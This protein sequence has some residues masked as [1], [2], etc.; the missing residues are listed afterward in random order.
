MNNFKTHLIIENCRPNPA[1]RLCKNRQSLTFLKNFLPPEIETQKAMQPTELGT[2]PLTGACPQV[3]GTLQP[4]RVA[5]TC[6]VMVSLS[7]Q[8][9]ADM[10]V[11]DGEA[12]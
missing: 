10:V 4:G 7:L 2:W 11:R 8:E 6:R 3:T 5:M 9:L 12:D 1:L